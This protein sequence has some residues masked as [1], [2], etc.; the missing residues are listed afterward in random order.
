MPIGHF[1]GSAR[2]TLISRLMSAIS[3]AMSAARS[4]PK[5][6]VRVSSVKQPDQ[7]RRA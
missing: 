5:T 3:Y 6:R 1:E 7:K 4:A 2:K